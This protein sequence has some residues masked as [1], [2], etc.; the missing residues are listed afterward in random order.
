MHADDLLAAAFLA[1]AYPDS[2]LTRTR[3]PAV[4]AQQDIVFDVGGVYD[5]AA[6]RFDHHQNNAPRKPDGTPYSSAGMVW[7]FLSDR[8]E[9][10]HPAADV[11]EIKNQLVDPVDLVD[12]GVPDP[13]HRPGGKLGLLLSSLN[14]N[15]NEHGVDADDRFLHG[16]SLL[17]GM[18]QDLLSGRPV[19]AAVDKTCTELLPFEARSKDSIEQARELVE[20]SLQQQ[21]DSRIL[22]LQQYLPWGDV[23]DPHAHPDLDYVV[24]PTPSK[25]WVVQAVPVTKGSFDLRLPM[26]ETWRG[27]RDGP[28]Q[29]ASG[30]KDAVFCHKT[31]FCAVTQGLDGALSLALK[32]V[33][34]SR[35]FDVSDKC[36]EKLPPT[37]GSPPRQKASDLRVARA[38][39][40]QIKARPSLSTDM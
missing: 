21:K 36:A 16:Q 22:L 8:I 32:A 23:I 38:E 37:V 18:V 1:A 9:K 19:A 7:A 27:L 2:V 4:L 33:A 34:V 15:W 25:T 20:E 14:A 31:G 26:P 3:D 35:G 28:L 24:F 13:L 6:R 11:A 30:L 5:P 29:A 40:A 10:E 12:N 39:A 17:S